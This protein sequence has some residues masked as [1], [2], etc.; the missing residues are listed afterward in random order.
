MAGRSNRQVPTSRNK[1]V[2]NIYLNKLFQEGSVDMKSPFMRHLV[3]Q[4]LRR[5]GVQYENKVVKH[6]NISRSSVPVDSA[7]IYL[8]DGEYRREDFK[9][10]WHAGWGNALKINDGGSKRYSEDPLANQGVDRRTTGVN[11]ATRMKL[12]D[13]EISEVEKYEILSV[14]H[15]VQVGLGIKYPLLGRIRETTERITVPAGWRS[16]RLLYIGHE[17]TGSSLIRLP[18]E[19]VLYIDEKT[20]T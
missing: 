5:R 1:M 15:S 3:R 18:P 12:F 2:A 19:I 20:F 11:Q 13:P 16:R 14:I 9:D 17:D 4:E 6:E 7:Y 10:G 8:E